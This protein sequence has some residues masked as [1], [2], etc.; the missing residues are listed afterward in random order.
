MG[1]IKHEHLDRPLPQSLEDVVVALGEV[2]R[3]PAPIV[4]TL[5]LDLLQLC[6]LVNSRKNTS[7]PWYNQVIGTKHDQFL[8]RTRK[9]ASEVILRMWWLP[10]P[11][12]NEHLLQH[13]KLPKMTPV[14]DSLD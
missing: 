9:K 1:N 2:R 11:S 13:F 6:Q 10:I 8:K 5:Q 4:L 14:T 3:S 12:V 7:Q